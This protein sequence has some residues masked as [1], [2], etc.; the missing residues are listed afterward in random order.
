MAAPWPASEN[1][2]TGCDN[3]A[4]INSEFHHWTCGGR[5]TPYIWAHGLMSSIAAEDAAGTPRGVPAGIRAIRY[6]ARGHGL[7]PPGADPQAYVWDS[8]ARDMLGIADAADAPDFIAGGSSMG[9][10]TALS[11]ALRAPERVRAL[12]LMLPPAL[13]EARAASAKRYRAA[14]LYASAVGGQK[15]AEHVAQPEYSTL[16]PWLIAHAPALLAHSGSGTAHLSMRQLADLMRGA[17][18]SN[19]PPRAAL[20]RVAAIPALILGWS[21]DTT[22][23][24]ASAHELHALLPQSDLFI[25][26]SYPDYLQFAARIDAFLRRFAAS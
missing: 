11:A 4:M 16:P 2:R 19:L 25:A 5:G 15:M 10:M 21:G 3:G 14:A 7:T 12:V 18:L 1:D 22:H 8:L 20:A 23:P 6:D 9:A 13:W 17:A 24:E 26:R